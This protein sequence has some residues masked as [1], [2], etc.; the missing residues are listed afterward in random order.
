MAAEFPGEPCI[1]APERTLTFRE[2]DQ[3]VAA[4]ADRLRD[5]CRGRQ[6]IGLYLDNSWQCVA[7]TWAVVRAGG[8]ACPISTREP[9]ERVRKMLHHVRAQVLVTDRP[10]VTVDGAVMRVSDLLSEDSP[11]KPLMMSESF[12]LDRPVSV[13]FTSGSTG[14]PKAVQH[15]FGNHFFSAKGS[16]VNVPL[17]PG[18]RWLLALPLYHVS[19][20]GVLFRCVLSG[21]T[22]VIP[23][24][25]APLAATLSRSGITHV[26]MVATQLVRLLREGRMHL[27]GG[28][29]AILLGGSPIPRAVVDEAYD[30]NLPIHVTY[31]LTE[32]TSQVSTTPPD[33]TR[34]QL[35]SA[36][37]VLPY[38][39]VA[40]A[41]DG[42]LL[43]RGL[44]RFQ[45]YLEPDGLRQPFDA[46]GWFRTGDLGYFDADGFLYV[47]GRKD[48]LFISGGENIQPEEIEQAL[49]SIDGVVRAVV[50]PV[51]DEEFGH[52]PVAFV[53]TDPGRED[54]D[55]VGRQ[56]A[57][58]LPRFKVPAAFYAWPEED[59]GEE[60]KID[61]ASFRR[62][63][64]S[65]AGDD[66]EATGSAHRGS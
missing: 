45:G 65:R 10:D 53:Q 49:A 56:L 14:T 50:V 51:P 2:M 59:P 63:A 6:R 22:M 52:R 27:L 42:E 38:R 30:R 32:M 34:E 55:E 25:D 48:N 18:D 1:V 11:S 39:Q 57:Q 58:H 31:G 15:S 26:S 60:V 9:A 33:A 13:V 12:R 47:E 28:V 44:T 19:G 66:G 40:V 37:T 4:L 21:A 46:G 20:L 35:Y 29:K 36:G 23:P 3:Q 43:V 7:A 61:R 64:A 8:V 24:R 62:L 54:L 5:D 16:N 17:V 41:E